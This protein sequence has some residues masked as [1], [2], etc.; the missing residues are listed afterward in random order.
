MTEYADCGSAPI[1]QFQGRQESRA[2]LIVFLL[3]M[4]NC[5][6]VLEGEVKKKKITADSALLR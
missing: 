4:Q 5:E 6:A 1:E 3:H 2:W